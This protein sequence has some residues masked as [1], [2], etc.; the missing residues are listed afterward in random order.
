[1]VFVFQGRQSQQ[2]IAG[3][4]LQLGAGQVDGGS[5][6]GRPRAD[7]DYFAVHVSFCNGLDFGR[8]N[9]SVILERGC[10]SSD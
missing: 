5:V 4:T 9:R 10:G 7:D 3:L 1:M 8:L 6:G 2:G